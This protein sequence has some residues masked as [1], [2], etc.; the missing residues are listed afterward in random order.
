MREY[1]TEIE[2]LKIEKQLERSST[3]EGTKQTASQKHEYDALMND[4]CL[5]RDIVLGKSK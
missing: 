1:E 3:K 4:L 5:F 2:S